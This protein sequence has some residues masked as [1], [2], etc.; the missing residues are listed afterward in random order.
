M[1]ERCLWRSLTSAGEAYF[2]RF[3]TEL[4]IG[5]PV[6]VNG[7]QGLEKETDYRCSFSMIGYFFSEISISHWLGQDR[8]NFKG[9][10]SRDEWLSSS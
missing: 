2:D 9:Y 7:F 10:T 4:M 1:R 5:I 3:R 6:S 8:D